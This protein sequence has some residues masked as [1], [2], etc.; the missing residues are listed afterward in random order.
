MLKDFESD[1]NNY[2][3][4][5]KYSK[6]KPELEEIYEKFVE[7]AK[8]RSKSTKFEEVES[9]SYQIKRNFS[10]FKIMPAGCICQKQVHWGERKTFIRYIRNQYYF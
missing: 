7:G 3:E 10:R 8:L 5:Q 9:S 6:I 2:N 1:L 4:L